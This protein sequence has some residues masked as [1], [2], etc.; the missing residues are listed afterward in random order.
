MVTLPLLIKLAVY[1][2]DKNFSIVL[3][4]TFFYN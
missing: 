2:I 4:R 1:F 3:F